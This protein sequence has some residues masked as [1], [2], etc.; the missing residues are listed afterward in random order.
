MGEG[1]GEGLIKHIIFMKLETSKKY[2]SLPFEISLTF[3][4]PLLI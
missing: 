4:N 3:F 2:L 1:W